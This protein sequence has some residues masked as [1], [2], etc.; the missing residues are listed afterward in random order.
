MPRICSPLRLTRKGRYSSSFSAS[1]ELLRAMAAGEVRPAGEDGSV[2]KMAHTGFTLAGRASTQ[3]EPGAAANAAVDGHDAS[4]TPARS[5][6]AEKLLEY[7]P[8]LV[9]LSGEQIRGILVGR[10]EKR[11][12]DALRHAGSGFPV[13][14]LLSSVGSFIDGHLF[15]A[16]YLGIHGYF[17][18]ERQKTRAL[19]RA[20]RPGAEERVTV[21][22]FVD[23]MDEIHGVATMYRNLQRLADTPRDDRLQLVQCGLGEDGGTVR[24][25]PVATVPMPLYEGR[26]LGVPSLLDVLDHVAEAG[27][28][29]LHV[30]TPGPLGLAALIAGSTLGIPI[31]GAYHTEFGAY[32]EVLSGD[33]MV[34]EI[35]EVLV[36]EFYQR[37]AVVAVSS[38]STVRALTARGYQIDRFEVLKNGVDTRLFDP[39]YREEARH[40]AL[41]GGRTL[42]LYAGRVSREKGLE[43]LAEDYLALRAR[44]DDVQLVIAGDGPFRRELAAKLG[45]TATF[46][47]FLRGEELA[48]TF[49]ACDLFVFPSTTDTLGRAV[50]EAQASGLPAV[51]FGLGGPREC[52]R[53]GVSGFV[54]VAGAPT[55]SR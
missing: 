30:A 16:P 32:A 48:R 22:V 26:L 53:P 55:I 13:L 54:V 7:L 38:E 14:G 31:V 34:A 41:G 40:R 49:A 25:R 19:R 23:E 9:N 35:V 1:A 5:A 11:L 10:Y 43:R 28:D 15:I 46:T 4:P 50:A 45:E 17:G 33:A 52:I 21:G 51:V 42:L 36:R 18:R 29:A 20:L 39:V 24:L 2:A 37:C 27:Y 47:G 8:F 12:A 44:R 3:G 6:E